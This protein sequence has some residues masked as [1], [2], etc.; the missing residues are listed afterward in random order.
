MA[1]N[2]SDISI[3]KNLMLHR[4]RNYS[5]E[6][7]D[8]L[9]LVPLIILF[10]FIV[11]SNS[12]R[13]SFVWDD[14]ILIV[15][16]PSIK[17]F[18]V[19]KHIFSRD[20]FDIYGD[21]IDFKYGYW[22]PV[23]TLSYMIDYFMWG[24]NPAGFHL[25]NILLHVL[26]CLLIYFI[27]S[28]DFKGWTVPFVAAFFFAIHPVHTESVSWVA[29][30]TDVVA[31]TFFLLSFL[32][33]QK[34]IRNRE[35]ANILSYFFSII[36][37][38]VAMISKEMV[39][40]LP[41]VLILYRYFIVGNGDRYENLKKS[42]LLSIPYFFVVFVYMYV[43]FGVL[44]I[45]VTKN[46]EN[47]PL[48]EFYPTLLSFIKSILVYT[49]KLLYPVKLNA[50]IQNPPS[51]TIL[52]PMVILSICFL[53]VFLV[54]LIKIKNREFTFYFLFFLLTFLPLSNF[55]RIS[56]PTDMGFV[57]AERFLYIPSFPFVTLF[58]MLVSSLVRNKK[59]LLLIILIAITL[60][61]SYKIILRNKDYVDD[62]VFFIKAIG[63]SPNAPLLHQ[64]LGNF[65]IRKGLLEEALLTYK[66]S[67]DLYPDFFSARNNI[68]TIYTKMGFKKE[69][70]AEFKN[71][72]EIRP[73]Y[74]LP[75]YNL[76]TL[77]GDIGNYDRAIRTFETAL[78]INP[79]YVKAHNGL[80][81]I[82]A[83]KGDFQRA[84]KEFEEAINVDPT[85]EYASYNLDLIEKMKTNS[86]KEVLKE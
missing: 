59:S 8:S 60:F 13:C 45:E 6:K 32:F 80:G 51:V 20:F 53:A 55:L 84:K 41:L 49:G 42:I 39:I 76:G 71:A 64:C 4:I 69:A 83:K 21:A 70:I 66:R 63:Q 12:L 40:I 18:T 86:S 54:A 44:E 36:L 37:F 34:S 47:D 10:V 85:Y 33:Y 35:K 62:E 1:S 15:E 73:S 61:F 19:I 5:P 38:A 17:T 77:Y 50:Y 23:V 22:R 65:Y 74:L 31:A 58:A 57:M 14:V 30:R 72:I 26:N 29:G 28:K 7:I 16:N 48:F 78:K 24:L 27:L 9:I 11:Y 79:K 68:A 52:E 75:Y 2:P 67:L 56:A 81:I 25:T 46:M 82:Y 3:E 43:R